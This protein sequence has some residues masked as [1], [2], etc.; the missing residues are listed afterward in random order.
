MSLRS[1]KKVVI[2]GD[3]AVGK[4]SLVHRYLGSLDS[5]VIQATLGA[6]IINCQLPIEGSEEKIPCQ[7]W[8][9]S[10]QQAFADM[11]GAF[12]AKADGAIIV[13]DITRSDTF[14]NIEKW[15]KELAATIATKNFPIVLIGNKE[16]IRG[17]DSVR[18][19]EVNEISE[20]LKDTYS[21]IVTSVLTSALSGD[22][23][24]GAFQELSTLLLSAFA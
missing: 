16:D 10:G 7:F 9:L 14:V 18:F 15:A 12:L 13:F 8:D 6:D 2:V 21:L 4:T 5:T 19:D 24:T 20:I 17:E 11:R 22:G 23:V 1:A 3:F